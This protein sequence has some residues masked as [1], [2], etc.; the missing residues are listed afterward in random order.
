MGLKECRIIYDAL[1]EEKKN[2]AINCLKKEIT[3]ELK[4]GLRI[5]IKK[6]PDEWF[7]MYH[8]GWGTAIR[9]LL[10]HKGFGEKYFGINNLDDIYVELVED[11][12]KERKNG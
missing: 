12:V 7:A 6:D 4:I 5:L 8:R 10:R 3:K 11:A 2:K 1:S 9:N